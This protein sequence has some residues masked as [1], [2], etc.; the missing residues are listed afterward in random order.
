M[1]EILEANKLLRGSH[2]PQ[3]HRT[4]ETAG[5]ERLAVGGEGQHVDAA[6]VSLENRGARA[7]IGMPQG[8]N[9]LGS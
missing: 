5:G 4:V 3:T 1:A 9:P 7:A 2:V 8:N 6:G